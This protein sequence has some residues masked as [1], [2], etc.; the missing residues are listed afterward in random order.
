MSLKKVIDIA[1]GIF[2]KKDKK[3]II[4]EDVVKAEQ[5]L[6]EKDTDQAMKYVG[7]AIKKYSELNEK[8]NAFYGRINRIIQNSQK[9]NRRELMCETE[10]FGNR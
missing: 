6:E 3:Q 2:K 9:I 10:Y 5:A 7:K 1:S 4:L 8:N